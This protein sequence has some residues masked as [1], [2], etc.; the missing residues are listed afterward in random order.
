MS[1]VNPFDATTCGGFHAVLDQ[2]NEDEDELVE[3]YLM[4]PTTVEQGEE[5]WRGGSRPG[6]RANKDE[7]F[8][9]AMSAYSREDSGRTELQ[10]PRRRRASSSLDLS[11]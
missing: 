5:R 3:R 8:S 6:K 11:V 7:T 9:S 1:S 4:Y 10:S 2:D